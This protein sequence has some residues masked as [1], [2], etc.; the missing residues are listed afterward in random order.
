MRRGIRSEQVRAILRASGRRT[1]LRIVTD[2]G[3]SEGTDR[4]SPPA[5]LRSPRKHDRSLAQGGRLERPAPPVSSPRTRRRFLADPTR[6]H[7]PVVPTTGAPCFQPRESPCRPSDFASSPPRPC[8]DLPGRRFH[9]QGGGQVTLNCST[10]PGSAPAWATS[11]PRRRASSTSLARP[12]WP[13]RRWRPTS[14]RAAITP[15]RSTAPSHT[16]GRSRRNYSPARRSRPDVN[17]RPNEAERPG[18]QTR[19]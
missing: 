11:T 4:S 7:A 15:R 9:L 10:S 5:F 18:V 19:G 13:E 16:R 1:G 12:V 14:I 8:L 6:L 17:R 3:S 2:R